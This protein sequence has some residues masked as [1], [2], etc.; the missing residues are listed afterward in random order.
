MLEDDESVV[1]NA[2]VMPKILAIT[3]GLDGKERYGQEGKDQ[4]HGAGSD[5][6][7]NTLRMESVV[8]GHGTPESLTLP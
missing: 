3:P 2:K 6:G 5:C 7:L 4:Q 1:A 8:T